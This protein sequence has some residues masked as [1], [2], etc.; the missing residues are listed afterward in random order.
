MVVV[1]RQLTSGKTGEMQ[2]EVSTVFLAIFLIFLSCFQ[3]FK[4]TFDRAVL[5]D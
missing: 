5:G 1:G 3:A 4:G 2:L